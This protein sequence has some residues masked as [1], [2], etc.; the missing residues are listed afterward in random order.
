MANNRLYLIHRPSGAWVQLGTRMGFGWGS[1]K[2]DLNER[3]NNFFQLAKESSDDE[4]QDEFILAMENVPRVTAD[5]PTTDWDYVW[6]DDGT[7][8]VCLKTK[9]KVNG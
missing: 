8:D 6:K 7:Y 1:S 3:I 4:S 5:A 2:F 9:E